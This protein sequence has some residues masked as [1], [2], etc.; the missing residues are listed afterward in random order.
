MTLYQ[1]RKLSMYLLVQQMIS[2]TSE[3]I[4]AKMP[5]FTQTYDLFKSEVSEINLLTGNHFLK[6]GGNIIDK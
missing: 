6:R 2:E 5:N 4:I 1:E 3:S